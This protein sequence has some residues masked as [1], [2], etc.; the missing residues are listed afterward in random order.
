MNMTEHRIGSI[1]DF[2]NGDKRIVTVSGI[3]VGVFLIDGAFYAWR[4]VC[5]HQGGPVCQGRMFK[6]VVEIVSA[7][8]SVNGRR[9]DE[10]AQHIVCPWHGGE[11]DIRTG[12]HGGTKKLA[13]DPVETIVRDDEVYL[14]VA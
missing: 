4:N 1:V 5:P 13:L 9:Y 7:D 6:R 10:H 11:F 3:E 12:Y 2:R 8:G 14:R